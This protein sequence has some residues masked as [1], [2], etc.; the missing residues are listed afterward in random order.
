VGVL[1]SRVDMGGEITIEVA[2]LFCDGEVHSVL[3]DPALAP[4][5][6]SED[7]Q[8]RQSRE[9]TVPSDQRAERGAASHVGALGHQPTRAPVHMS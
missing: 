5:E 6:I 9:H 7:T 3:G 2:R 1:T 8:G 4:E